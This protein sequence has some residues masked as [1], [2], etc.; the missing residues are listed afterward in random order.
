METASPTH[1]PRAVP[2]ALT[3]GMETCEQKRSGA[4]VTIPSELLLQ[5]WGVPAEMKPVVMTCTLEL[6]QQPSREH[7]VAHRLSQVSVS[8]QVQGK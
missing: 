7:V 1:G 4:S 6:G 2:Q 8:G 5:V 3:Q